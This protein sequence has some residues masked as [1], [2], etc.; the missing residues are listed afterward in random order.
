MTGDHRGVR[1]RFPGSNARVERMHSQCKG[2][3]GAVFANG[4]G[5]Q[6]HRRGVEPRPLLGA[7]FVSATARPSKGSP[8]RVA[9]ETAKAGAIDT[10]GRRHGND[11]M[12]SRRR[13]DTGR[14]ARMSHGARERTKWRRGSL[15]RR[16]VA[17]ACGVLLLAG[18]LCPTIALAGPDTIAVVQGET[19]SGGGS[20]RIASRSADRGK[21]LKVS[22]GWPASHPFLGRRARVQAAR[23]R[24]RRC[25]RRCAGTRAA[26]RWRDR[27][28]RRLSRQE[29]APGHRGAGPGRGRTSPVGAPEQPLP[30]R[31]LSTR[32]LP[33]RRLPGARS[34]G[35]ADETH[36]GVGG[37]DAARRPAGL[38]A[39][40]RGRL[41]SGRGAGQLPAG[42]RGQVGR[43]P[44]L[45]AR[46]Q[47]AAHVRP[48]SRWLV[49]PGQDRLHR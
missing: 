21:V 7:W 25:L 6:S 19:L 43:L 33:R 15:G 31:G 26:D 10:T 23:Q 47:G 2:E 34:L 17:R 41:R 36:V 35:A 4:A 5:A 46:H 44:V 45:L 49:P 29:L 18:A 28:E 38:E 24:R 3:C 1:R 16:P 32:G 40:L 12:S 8:G 48:G 27:A 13:T 14:G 11:A 30:A 37:T 22:S 20:N 9:A 39:D 42:G